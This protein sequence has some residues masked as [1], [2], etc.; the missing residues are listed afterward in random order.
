MCTAAAGDV[1]G[2]RCCFPDCVGRFCTILADKESGAFGRR[3]D[4]GKLP[5][6]AGGAATTGLG[7]SGSSPSPE[8]PEPS[9]SDSRVSLLSQ[10]RCE[11][12]VEH[13]V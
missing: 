9:D 10:L 4:S 1:T 12:S 5:G 6:T 13:L 8:G 2:M 3:T 7:L 11:S